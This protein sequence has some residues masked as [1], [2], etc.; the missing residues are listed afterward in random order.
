MISFCELRGKKKIAFQTG[1]LS[2][3]V[4][5]AGERR[6]SIR[7]S[8]PLKLSS[9]RVSGPPGMSQQIIVGG[10]ALTV[11]EIIA[12]ALRKAKVVLD[13]ATLD[14]VQQDFDRK[15]RG[16]STTPWQI[17]PSPATPAPLI[18]SSG[19]GKC[20][21]L[22][23]HETLR[24]VVL[25]RLVT[26]L[27]QQS[28]VRPQ[29]AGYLTEL[30]NNGE[31][32]AASDILSELQQP[33]L[34]DQ[35][36][37][38]L[39]LKHYG[40][41]GLSA[42]EASVFCSAGYP[43]TVARL[44]MSWQLGQVLA[45][46]ADC[47]SVLAIEALQLPTPFLDLDGRRQHEGAVVAANRIK[48]LLEE[49][50]TAKKPDETHKTRLMARCVYVH[51]ALVDSLEQLMRA[52]RPE[53]R[54]F[55]SRKS[56]A[57][58]DTASVVE[59]DED[60]NALPLMV[61]A[62]SVRE[63]TI[64]CAK[65]AIQEAELVLER[66]Q[67]TIPEDVAP[68]PDTPASADRTNITVPPTAE[69]HSSE[70]HARLEG[71]LKDI[72]TSIAAFQT[73]ALPNGDLPSVLTDVEKSLDLLR[74]SVLCEA[75]GALQIFAKEEVD[76]YRKA[77]EAMEKKKK[78]VSTKLTIGR[79]VERFRQ[80][81]N[82]VVYQDAGGR[83]DKCDECLLG[84]LTAACLIGMADSLEDILTVR[85]QETRKP[86]V[87]KGTQDYTPIQMAIRKQVMRAIADVFERH[88][89]VQ[90]DTPV[91]ELKETLMGKYGE[92]QKLIYDLKDQ[93][94]EQLSLRYDL[95]V[96][97][98][99]FCALGN[100]EKIKRYHIG[101]V[102]RRDEPQLAK[103]RF[104]EF[105]QCDFDI[106]GTYD[107]MLPD[108]EVITVFCEIL[109]Q[110]FPNGGFQV[111]INHRKLL[112]AIMEVC[113]V[114]QQKFRPI[115][116]AIDKLDKE[117]W[118]N[119]KREMIDE[120]GLREEVADRIGEYVVLK[121][122]PKEM[123]ERL[124]TMT[125]LLKSTS[126]QTALSEMKLLVDYVTALGVIDRLCLDLSLARGLEY[127]TG[128]IYEAVT[129]SGESGI[130]SVGGGGRYDHLVGMFAGKDIPAV[131]VS[132][133][134]ERV[135]AAIESKFGLK[136]DASSAAAS[137]TA[138]D[139]KKGGKS[140]GATRDGTGSQQQ[141][142]SSEVHSVVRDA[143]TDV[144]ICTIGDNLLLERLAM[145]RELWDAG[146]ACE[147]V[148]VEKPKLNKQLNH[149]SDNKIPLAVIMGEDELSKGVVKVRFLTHGPPAPQEA[150][151]ADPTSSSNGVNTA[152][153]QDQQQQQPPE[154]K[155]IEVERGALVSRL[156]GILAKTK[157]SSERLYDHII[158]N[159]NTSS[160]SSSSSNGN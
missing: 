43:W 23:S 140:G 53:L 61:P 99:R 137:E 4:S 146:I 75:A 54:A 135:F 44:V 149:A 77:L 131:G 74:R 24:A 83:M 50:K 68:L 59:G 17:P 115:C 65:T 141:Q 79:P 57:E 136:G 126:A 25:L 117:P 110:F 144:L 108:A 128:V 145:A 66:N 1:D 88:G 71:T 121:G 90:I 104:R 21:P 31:D 39:L 122:R 142:Q 27:H 62:M 107:T 86:K 55:A 60:L 94:G 73:S 76:K 35:Q 48:W 96:P 63:A 78:N 15:F 156:R 49:S 52:I 3:A 69:T 18:P 139:K 103:G 81:L 36:A 109:D 101:K 147:F 100:V 34:S 58:G 129:L 87:A 155:E 10:R 130:G 45:Q 51:G 143:A 157:T 11:G 116:S 19:V 84:Q 89:A 38:Q 8:V 95:T 29:V 120:K 114:P 113:G 125:N 6:S 102:Y 80:C 41:E 30:L 151:A 67:A 28:G 72:K 42:E 82:S 9:G 12:V 40:V 91:F 106:A 111:K 64:R 160:S 56:V 123:I 158:N 33:A 46:M 7:P 154:K 112:D 5:C 22:L 124:D 98:A 16:S 32:K 20:P 132:I 92:D 13:R 159:T 119:V 134:I 85:N 14:K 105:Y 118:D 97:F 150:P 148:Y 153:T 26:V 70:S 133:G 93:G 2:V 37:M 127:Y 138:T 47:S 152:T